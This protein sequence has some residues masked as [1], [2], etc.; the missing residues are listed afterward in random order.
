MERGRV[1]GSFQFKLISVLHA[2]YDFFKVSACSVIM[3]LKVEKVVKSALTS[4]IEKF[5]RA[6]AGK[7][8]EKEGG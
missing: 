8:T 7:R 2:R 4:G 5:E 3:T 1:G 6:R